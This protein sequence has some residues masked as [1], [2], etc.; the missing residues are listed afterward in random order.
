MI[1]F[2]KQHW[3]IWTATCKTMKSKHSLIPYTKINAK[4]FKELNLRHDTTNR[5]EDDTGKIFFDI[6]C[7]NMFL[8]QSHKAKN[9]I[10]IKAGINKCDLIKL[11]KFLHSK[12]NYQ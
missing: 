3:E 5:L 11:K 1:S 6:N 7:S 4:W 2:N 9:K 10:K 8:D 12:G